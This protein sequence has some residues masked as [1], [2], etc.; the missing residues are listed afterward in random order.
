MKRVFLVCVLILTC[1]VHA[2]SCG[3]D[4]FNDNSIDAS[5]W[6]ELE[7]NGS[8]V[9]SEINQRLEY[10]TTNPSEAHISWGWNSG[11][12]YTQDWA[13]VVDTANLVN[14]GALGA[15]FTV[16]DLV[17]EYGN[18]FFVVEH[19]LQATGRDLLTIVDDS[20]GFFI[21][22]YFDPLASQFTIKIAFDSS[23]KMLESSY[24]TGGG[25]LTITNYSVAGWGMSASSEFTPFISAG[26][27]DFQV[28]SGMV[29]IDNF[30][31]QSPSCGSG[32]D[33]D[34]DDLP[35]AW[36]I[37]YFGS[38]SVLPSGHGDN[39]TLDNLSEY[40]AGTDPTNG[41]SV[42]EVSSPGSTSSGFVLNW[43][44]MP[45]RVYGV[46]WA[47]SLTNGFQPMATDID[48]P[49]NSYT[50]TVHAAGGEGFYSIDVKLG[51]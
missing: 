18:N 47:E 33:V 14:Q 2:D 25:Y 16:F 28:P 26:S 38:T 44:A 43:N 3:G 41:A 19:F 17:L 48:Y 4:D 29:Y 30:E 50:D 39:D 49:Q 21:S 15:G 11:L 51:N 37:Q 20:S 1:R 10:I 6:S 22:D 5:K 35:D 13:V 8:A 24:N 32:G 36:E 27:T 45:G 42:F 7:V 23:T 9:F 46:N 12:S 34:G 31:V 40:I